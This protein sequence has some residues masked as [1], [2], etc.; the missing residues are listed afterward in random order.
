MSYT[1]LYLLCFY[2]NKIRG[3][4]DVSEEDDSKTA[5]GG[6]ILGQDAGNKTIIQFNK[7]KK[8]E[9]G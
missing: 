3:H 2:C 5:Q 9:A 4:S 7:E 6:T 8:E 1:S